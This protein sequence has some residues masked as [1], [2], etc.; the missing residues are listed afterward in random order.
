MKFVPTTRLAVRWESAPDARHDVGTLAL[1]RGQL[2]FEYDAAWRRKKLELAPFTL[3][4]KPG[5]IT[6]A[7]EKFDGLHGVFA[8]SLPD[9]WG[10]LLLDRKLAAQ[11]I[12]PF[13]AGPLDRLSAVGSRGIGA[14]V[15][16]PD[17]SRAEPTVIKLGELAKDIERVFGEQ[18]VDI[19]RLFAL[20]G[21]PQ[22]ARPKA[23]VWLDAKGRI[24]GAPR[25]DTSAWLV[26]FPSPDDDA[27]SGALEHAYALMAHAAGINLPPTQLLPGARRRFFAIRRFDLEGT[28]RTH[29]LSLA[30]LLDAP[31][32]ST[33][34]D[35]RA[36]LLA[37][38]QLTRHEA[39]VTET[40]RRACFNVL[41][42]NRDDHARNFA[43]VMNS[44]GEWRTSPAFDLTFSRGPGAQHWM[45]V[46]LAQLRS[47]AKKAGVTNS[48][49]TLTRVRRAVARFEHFARTAQVPSRLTQ[50]VL[51]VLDS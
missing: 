32:G 31:P 42:H 1:H 44:R 43:F 20:G 47:L 26:K 40:F 49:Q 37:T 27:A 28:R 10:R 15:Y 33:A 45:T 2:H 51:H 18:P 50:R 48:E 35:Y 17:T 39:D 24:F 9:G 7:A 41:A 6:A 3:P 8:D 13:L 4:L 5:V 22:G 34:L 16:E 14:L 46:D 36:L 21:S 23:L 19:D 29:V 30:A 38:R 12:D 25:S 11:G